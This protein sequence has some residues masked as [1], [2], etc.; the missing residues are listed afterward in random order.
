MPDG[1]YNLIVS[2]AWDTLRG[3]IL[4]NRVTFDKLFEF[5]A[6]TLDREVI[7]RQLY[8]TTGSNI[9]SL[10][11]KIA[12]DDEYKNKLIEKFNTREF[13]K[14]GSILNSGEIDALLTE[15]NSEDL[16][17]FARLLLEKDNTL[18]DRIIAR[19]KKL[20]TVNISDKGKALVTAFIDTFSD[21]PGYL[22]QIEEVFTSYFKKDVSFYSQIRNKPNAEKFLIYFVSQNCLDSLIKYMHTNFSK[23][24]FGAK[25][26]IV[27]DLKDKDILPV[28]WGFNFVKQALE[29]ASNSVEPDSVRLWL[30]ATKGFIEGIEDKDSI[31]SVYEKLQGAYVQIINQQSSKQGFSKCYTA[32][33]DITR[34]LFTKDKY[35]DEGTI[36][37]IVRGF[38]NMIKNKQFVS[39]TKQWIQDVKKNQ[40]IRDIIRRTVMKFE[41]EN[42]EQSEKMELRDLLKTIG[43]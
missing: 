11:F 17:A 4:L 5:I 12:K 22:S 39:E 19:I 35:Y 6:Y 23:D 16:V 41:K 21:M 24:N 34:E 36:T 1:T 10:I 30:E 26:N 32:F 7:K 18:A 20:D 43:K 13:K 3:M 42:I 27:R 25:V 14:I 29:F 8:Q 31:K 37:S 15:F 33:L 38:M 9:L 28:K 40:F 2:Q